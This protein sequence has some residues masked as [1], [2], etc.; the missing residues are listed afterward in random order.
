MGNH[1]RRFLCAPHATKPH[2]TQKNIL[3]Y[4]EGYGAIQKSGTR[5]VWNLM[6][7]GVRVVTGW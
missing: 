6:Q 4:N 1:R 5:G 2:P 3:G 7:A